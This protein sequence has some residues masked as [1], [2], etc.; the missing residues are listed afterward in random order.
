MI[1]CY[2]SNEDLKNDIER[3]KY[4]FKKNYIG[5][6]FKEIDKNYTNNWK[7][8]KILDTA[9]F[10]K[11]SNKQLFALYKEAFFSWGKIIS[12]F[13]SSQA[14][15]TYYLVQ[16]LKKAFSD[17]KATLLMTPT[18]LDL[19]NRETLD[20]QKVLV[21]PYSRKRLMNHTR[22]YPWIVM[23]HYKLEDVIET[24]TQRYNFDKKHPLGYNFV[25]EKK[26]VKKKQK[27]LLKIHKDKKELVHLLQKIAVYRMKVKSCWAGLDFYK[28]K[29]VNEIAKRGKVSP[30]DI[31]KYYL[32]KDINDLLNG[33]P[34]SSD[35][36]KMRKKCFV[37]L[38][39]NRKAVY[40]SG[41]EAEKIAK[42]ELKGLYIIKESKEIK[43]IVANP[44]KIKGIARILPSNNI[45][46][47]RELRKSFR[48]G[49]ILITGMTQPNIIDIASR[50][51]AIITDEG[52]LLS[53]AAIISREFKI[54]CIV[55]THFGT[56]ILKDGD[57]VEVDANKGM[58]KILKKNNGS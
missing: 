10:K 7:I 57:L 18:E 34:L 30:I 54:P 53:H 44:G 58:V 33:K 42:R 12:Y 5:K 29:L 43:G 27:A 41:E 23:N 21:K 6:Y 26:E 37:A 52:G 47:T 25:N 1:Y 16:E 46:K 31:G 14:E 24:L 40:I 45:E 13:R 51:G 4:F 19:V 22:K 9:N 36:I 49:E 32:T 50:A 2:H 8:F 56:Q 55:G 20:W 35:E 11:Y 48:K 39:K 28:I 17:V 38:W 3:G 15:G